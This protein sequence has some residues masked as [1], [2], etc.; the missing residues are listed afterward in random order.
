MVACSRAA[1]DRLR[2]RKAAAWYTDLGVWQRY[3]DDWLDWHPYPVTLPTN[4]VKALAKS[5]EVIEEEG[6]AHRL[7]TQRDTAAAFRGAIT[8][9]GLNTFISD[10]HCAH[11][12]TAVAVEGRFA[13]SELVAYLMDSLGVEIAGSLGELKT[14]IFRVGHMSRVQQRPHNL[15]GVIVGIGTFMRRNGLDCDIESAL[16]RVVPPRG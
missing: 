4:C 16:A 15:A 5:A 13:P 3:H 11:G 12:L 6:L 10:A 14:E 1:A 7:A 2:G 8:A 9:L